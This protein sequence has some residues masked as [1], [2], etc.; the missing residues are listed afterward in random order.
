MGVTGAARW[1]VALDGPPSFGFLSPGGVVAPL[2]YS[3]APAFILAPGDGS[4]LGTTPWPD[5]GARVA[6]GA[7][8]TFFVELIYVSS[9]QSSFGGI[10][11]VTADG[12]TRWTESGDCDPGGSDFPA[13][14]E[15][16]RRGDHLI[17]VCNA[18]GGG[19]EVLE[20]DADDAEGLGGSLRRLPFSAASRSRRTTIS[21]SSPRRA[22]ASRMP[23]S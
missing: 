13:P 8:G 18:G 21:S 19:V 20:V 3:G 23:R 2:R 7:D 11:R 4:V 1:S 15:F 17:L 22:W 5:G 12:T 9:D 6:V 16:V 10:S 14:H